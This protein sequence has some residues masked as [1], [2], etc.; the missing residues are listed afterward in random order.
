MVRIPGRARPGKKVLEEFSESVQQMRRTIKPAFWPLF[1]LEAD[2]MYRWRVQLDCGCIDEVLTRG[3]GSLPADRQCQDPVGQAWLP[4]GEVWCRTSHET[5]SPYREIVEW[6]SVEVKE[7]PADPEDAPNW[8]DPE[9][10]AVIRHPEPHSSAFWR[11]QLTCGHYTDVPTD[12]EWRPEDGPRLV[13]TERAAEMLR[14]FEEFWA[15]PEA[16]GQDDD[17][18]RQHR[19][20]MLELRWPR[21]EPDKRCYTCSAVSK[22][23]GYQPIGWLLPRRKSVPDEAQRSGVQARLRQ[24]EAEVEKLRRQLDEFVD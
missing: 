16:D 19:R 1:I 7:F 22:I 11:V 14:E 21:P 13:T 20:Q 2:D 15:S 4:A 18:E 24:A 12:L 6:V 17:I 10:W 23:V 3:Q 5:P 8:L 9:T